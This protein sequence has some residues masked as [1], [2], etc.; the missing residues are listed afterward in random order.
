[1]GISVVLLAYREEENL[2][3]LLLRLKNKWKRV[4][5]RMKFCYRHG[6]SIGSDGS[7]M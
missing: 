2:R 7:C 3:V 6:E 1:M 4:G 5:N